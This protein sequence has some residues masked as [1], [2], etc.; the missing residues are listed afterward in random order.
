MIVGVVAEFNPFHLG[1]KYQIDKINEI[2]NPDLKVAVI[3]TNFVQRAELSIINIEDK[4]KMCLKAGYDIVCE[5]PAKYSIQN[6]EVFCNIST[7]MLAKLG[8]NVQVFGVELDNLD[9]LKEAK[10]ILDNANIKQYMKNGISYNKA[11]MLAL[12]ELSYVYTSNNILAMEYINTIEKYKLNMSYYPIKRKK[13]LLSASKIREDIKKLGLKN[14]IAFNVDKFIEGWEDRLFSLFKYIFQ[15]RDVTNTYD[16]N[17]QYLNY[18]KARIDKADSYNEF[19]KIAK[20]RNISPSRIK[21]IMLN[22]VL[23]IQKEDINL[24]EIGEIKVVGLSEK[25]GKYIKGLD[26][27]KVNYNENKPEDIL[28]KYLTNINRIR[29]VI[30]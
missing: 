7:R 20:D 9:I 30:R 12:G 26:F 8:V 18:I 3:S 21:R 27:V 13:G 15:T 4:V 23:N 28:Y 24:E 10:Y 22:V 25:G 6:A 16:L 2:F 5:I 19:L 29:K 11:C 14:E 1:H 17:I